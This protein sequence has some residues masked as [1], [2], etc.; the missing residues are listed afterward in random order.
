M[1]VKGGMTSVVF[2]EVLQ[3]VIMTAACIAIG[4]I[5]M[6]TVSPEMLK[7]NVPEGW[8]SML[9][10]WELGLDWSGHFRKC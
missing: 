4:V 5:A 3:F 6:T 2:T 8:D 9:F 10:G 1:S 7:A